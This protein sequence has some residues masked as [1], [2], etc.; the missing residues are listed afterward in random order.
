[1]DALSSAAS[2]MLA[3][4]RLQQVIMNNISNLSTPGFKQSS[5]QLMAFPNELVT[6][7][8][9][10]HSTSGQ[11]PVGVV[12]NG[13]LFQE[14]VSN[15]TQGT[16]NQ[17]GQPFDLAISDPV[18]TGTSVYALIPGQGNAAAQPQNVST[19]SFVVGHGGVIETTQGAP[20]L[21]VDVNGKP[22]AGA[23]VI[24]N[25]K[26]KGLD[27]FGETGSPVYDAAGQASYL[28][29]SI[30]GAPIT[31]ANGQ[32]GAFLHMTSSVTGGMHSFFAV[33]NIDASGGKRV[34]LTRDGHFQVG[35]DHLLY[36]ATGQRVLAIG[37]NSQPLL[38][39]AVLI[40]PAY[41]GKSYF[42]QGGQPLFDAAGNPSYRIVST[43]GRPLPGATFGAVSVD[44]NTLQALG[45]TDFLL[46]PTSVMKKSAA[47]IQAGALEQ[48]NA[49]DTQNMVDMIAV[50]RS[51]EANQRMVQTI[52][53]TL[54]KTVSDIGVVTG[55]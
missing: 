1:M 24:V 7:Y 21:P 3:D 4:E 33:E 10:G 53:T 19:P 12:N 48:S 31:Q 54:Q 51:Y 18:S 13:T 27:L 11:T 40:N 16:I 9:S 47:A 36:N 42:G 28:I 45:Q 17:T 14:S 29:K 6:R 35:S 26:Y 50:Y 38:N 39:S 37:A 49:N 43:T 2:G 8:L 34:A 23:R 32:P 41:Q 20:I 55:L 44:V 5:G 46:T 25:P 30:N 22:I 52:D 15:F